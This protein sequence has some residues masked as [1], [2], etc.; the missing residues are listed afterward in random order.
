MTYQGLK[1]MI[2]RY[3]V[4]NVTGEEDTKEVLQ[5]IEEGYKLLTDNGIHGLSVLY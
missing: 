3:G 5:L 4:V 1:D 2:E